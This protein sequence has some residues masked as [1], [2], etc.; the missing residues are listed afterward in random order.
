MIARR[1]LALEKGISENEH[2]G[3]MKVQTG[4][5]VREGSRP[6]GWV[7]AYEPAQHRGREGEERAQVNCGTTVKRERRE[8]SDRRG[9]SWLLSHLPTSDHGNRRDWLRCSLC[10][11]SAFSHTST[12]Q[13]S[14]YCVCVLYIVPGLLQYERSIR[15]TDNLSPRSPPSR[16]VKFLHLSCHLTH[17]RHPRPLLY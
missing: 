15:L 14:S 16:E 9:T 12:T 13:Q 6:S 17:K 10:S 7:T 5:M 1:S 4:E 8:Q 2:A 3:D 11:A